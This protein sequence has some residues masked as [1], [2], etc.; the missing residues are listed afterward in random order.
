MFPKKELKILLFKQFW[1]LA[2]S[3]QGKYGCKNRVEKFKP[4]KLE[5][6]KLFVAT[7]GERIKQGKSDPAGIRTQDPI[8]KRDVLYRLSY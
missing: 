6:G 1:Y 7:K 8:L 3:W 5:R 4:Q 2:V